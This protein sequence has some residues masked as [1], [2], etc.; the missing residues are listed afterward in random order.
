MIWPVPGICPAFC[1]YPEGQ[2]KKWDQCHLSIAR[3]FFLTMEINFIQNTFVFFWKVRRIFFE[4]QMNNIIQ[5]LSAN[6]TNWLIVLLF[7]L[8]KTL[9]EFTF[10]ICT[11]PFTDSITPILSISLWTLQTVCCI[12][13]PTIHQNWNYTFDYQNKVDIYLMMDLPE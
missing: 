8:I 7:L 9:F 5:H 11:V 1:T 12:M 6:Q 4:A 2:S 10:F 3:F 13:I